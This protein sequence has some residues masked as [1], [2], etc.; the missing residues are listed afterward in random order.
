ML[1]QIIIYQH[2]LISRNDTLSDIWNHY[3]SHKSII[4]LFE[5][6][7]SEAYWSRELILDLQSLSNYPPVRRVGDNRADLA[8]QFGVTT[9]PSIVIIDKNG[10]FERFPTK[11]ERES[12]L[13][14]LHEI[15][16]PTNAAKTDKPSIT[17]ETTKQQPTQRDNAVVKS[18]KNQVFMSDLEKAILYSLSHEVITHKLIDGRRFDALKDY[19][20]ILDLY[21][22]GR[23]RVKHV[24]RSVKKAL[25]LYE[26][27]IKGEEFA[28]LMDSVI[29]SEHPNWRQEVS[30][31]Q[32]CRGSQPHLR[33]YPC[34]L[35]TL[36]HVLTVSFAAEKGGAASS[37]ANGILTVIKGYVQHFFGCS[38]CSEH[39]VSMAEND[40]DP[41][42]S[43][44]EPNSSIM[45]LWRA[46]NKV[47]KRLAGDSTED[48]QAP[49]IQ[50]PSSEHC[51]LCHA[52]A[53]W[54]HDAVLQY[55]THM[56]SLTNISM[57]GLN[58]GNSFDEFADDLAYPGVQRESAASSINTSHW[59]SL[60]FNRFDI[61][62]CALVYIV[63]PLILLGFMCRII[64]K[65][66]YRKKMYIYD[67]TSKF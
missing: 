47:N 29:E 49:K 20:N 32:G 34:S 58:V 66:R 39:F 18:S 54:N 2:G 36:F 63:S 40:D 57:Q 24:I 43:V 21:F 65:R 11:A 64:F 56:Y 23:K 13:K 30:E 62:L 55:L 50:F 26:A 3:N 17:K 42:E 8:K 25:S 51:Q 14:M 53:D 41:I 19:V 52:N 1:D 67:I 10:E 7:A 27:D 22:P 9:L 45:W 5:Q 28:N 4:L 33:G 61:S 37:S 6:P 48:P 38:H 35:W 31:W 16:N 44:S 60:A 15:F 12:T 59:N 46:H